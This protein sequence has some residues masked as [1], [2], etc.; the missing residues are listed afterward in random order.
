M[1]FASLLVAALL[2]AAPSAALAQDAADKSAVLDC[3]MQRTTPGLAQRIADVITPGNGTDDI[4]EPRMAELVTVVSG[5]AREHGIAEAKVETYALYYLS[6]MMREEGARQLQA[7]GIP[8]EAI[9]RALD[10]GPGRANPL[11]LRVT[12]AQ[13]DDLITLLDAAGVDVMSISD[14][15]FR[16]IGIYAASIAGETNYA[17]ALE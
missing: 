6:R 10:V 13:T 12:P 7:L 8:L 17:S 15:T 4:G 9:H 14:G 11:S 2:V 3:P 1:K 5:C 16:V